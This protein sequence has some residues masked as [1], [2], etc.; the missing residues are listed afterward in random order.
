MSKNIL[1]LGCGGSA[2][3]NF[4]KSLKM[5]NQG[6]K[7]IGV[8]LD[9]YYAELAPVDKRYLLK[10]DDEEKYVKSLLKIIN[11]EQIDFI[12]AQPDVEVEILS[13]YRDLW[14][15]KVML[16]SEDAI[17]ICQDKYLAYKT[18]KKNKVP[19]ASTTEISN[20][21]DVKKIFK[22]DKTLWLRSRYSTGAGKASLPVRDFNQAKMWIE[23]WLDK[24][25]KVSDFIAS[26]L[27]TGQE[28]SWLSIW[29][30]GELICSQA[31]LRISWARPNPSPSG[32][33]GTSGVQKTIHS[34]K[35]NKVCTEA[36]LAVDSKPNGVYVVDTK[37]N[38]KG[39]PCVME[40]NIGRFFTTSMFFPSVGVNVP[41][42]YVKAALGEKLPQVKKYNCVP[43]DIYWIRTID[44]GPVMIKG[45]KWNHIKI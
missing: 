17:N 9:K 44:G 31:K 32:V 36:V 37:E 11:K 41:E 12:H 25:L 24:G 23:F 29:K 7:V 34:V 45:N 5:S 3:I 27:L 21:A 19:V 28:V 38:T 15:S 43:K 33:G 14:G 42:I 26:E 40:I 22:G 35:V 2:G 1:L 8:E 20:F 18:F 16:P 13:K 10:R 4:A 6:Y 39:I 30:D